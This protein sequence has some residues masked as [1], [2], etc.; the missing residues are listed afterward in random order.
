M[1]LSHLSGLLASVYHWITANLLTSPSRTAQARHAEFAVARFYELLPGCTEAVVTQATR[2]GGKDVIVRGLF[3]ATRHVEVKNWAGRVTVHEIRRMAEYAAEHGVDVGVHSTN[4]FTDAARE[5]AERE[6]VKLTTKSSIRRAQASTGLSG[7]ISVALGRKKGLMRMLAWELL[8]Q[9]IPISQIISTV[10]VNLAILLGRYLYV[11]TQ[12]VVVVVLR[13]VL[14]P[15]VKLI[16]IVVG[17][18]IVRATRRNI[19]LGIV[20]LV[21]GYAIYYVFFKKLLAND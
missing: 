21:F 11:F 15:A 7:A 10:V 17:G 2:D 19:A 20:V 1:T 3:G 9:F 12:A 8:N 6:G 5:L 4:G 13:W 16:A 18:I 14:I